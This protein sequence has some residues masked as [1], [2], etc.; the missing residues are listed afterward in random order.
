M[1]VHALVLLRPLWPVKLL[2]AARFLFS[3][4]PVMAAGWRFHRYAR[5]LRGLLESGAFDLV[6]L[7]GIWLGIYWSML[8]RYPVLKILNLYDVES[9]SLTRQAHV[10]PTR[11]GRWQYHNAA[12][13]MRHMEDRCIAEADLSWVTSRN[14]R[15]AFAARVTGARIEVA[16]NGVDCQRIRPLPPPEG[17]ELL[18][19]GSLNYF[20]NRDAILYFVREVFPLIRREMP[21]VTLRVVGRG[22]GEDVKAL[23]DPP[24]VE[25]TGEVDAVEPCYRRCAACIV[26]IRAGGG[27]RLKILEAMAYG[28][29]VISTR[30]GAEGLDIRPGEHFL[31]A[32]SHEQTV[33]AVKQ[34]FEQPE[35]TAR[36]IRRAREQVE[37]LY[38]WCAIA[39]KMTDT[40]RRL[41]KT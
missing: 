13:R 4:Y 28:R 26:P 37:Q 31:E 5:A 29:P 25:M 15:D 18:F 39:R 21:K 34:L 17:R 3:R 35:E 14:D 27:T 6:V 16:P 7:E 9:E 2:K 30:I 38:D 40:Y 23:H 11:F 1:D 8:Q 41:T 19:I 24:A 12:R 32:D 33:R 36:M 20:P 10:Q 22:P